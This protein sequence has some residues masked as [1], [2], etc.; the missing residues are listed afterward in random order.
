MSLFFDETEG[1]PNVKSILITYIAATNENYDSNRLRAREE[2][3]EVLEDIPIVEDV[4]PRETTENGQR[5]IPEG[6]FNCDFDFGFC[7]YKQVCDL[8]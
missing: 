5:A 6:P 4:A 7:N 2:T 3:L 8:P 1:L